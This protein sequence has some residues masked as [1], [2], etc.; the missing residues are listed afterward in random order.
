MSE[1]SLKNTLSSTS[2]IS[3]T[4]QKEAFSEPGLKNSPKRYSDTYDDKIVARIKEIPPSCRLKYKR[5]M[6]GKSLRTAVTSFCLECVHWERKEITNCTS[7]ICPLYPYR[8]YR[9]KR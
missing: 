1:K 5:A 3:Q 4:P 6:S 8:P 7:T 9:K 2:T